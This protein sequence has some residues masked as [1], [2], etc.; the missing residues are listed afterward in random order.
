MTLSIAHRGDPHGHPENT[1]PAVLAA[2]EQGA[3]LVEVDLALTRD[4]TVVLVHDRTL[5]RLW[6]RDLT[7]ADASF[8][9]LRQIRSGR[10]GR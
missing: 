9:E 4:G 8:A 1:I 10:D 6:G 3:D 2:V 7:V 5:T